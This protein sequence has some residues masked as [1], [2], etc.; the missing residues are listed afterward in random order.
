MESKNYTIKDIGR[1]AGVSAG[2]VDRVLHNRGDVSAEAMEKVQKVLK[3]IDYHPNMFAIGLAAKKRYNIVCMLPYSEVYNNY[4][5]AVMQGINFA[6]TEFKPFNVK[7]DFLHYWHSDRASYEQAC[8]ELQKTSAD[9]VLIAPNFYTET[10]ELTTHLDNKQIPYVFVDYNVANTYPLCYIGQ[11]SRVSGYMA[12]KLLMQGYKKGEELVLFMNNQKENPAE[13]QMQRRM[14][15]FM[16]Y[17][18]EEQDCLIIHDVILDKDDEVNARVLD[19]FFAAHPAAVLGAV[20][21]SRIYRVASHLHENGMKLKRL[22]GYD[23]LQKNI[24]FMKSGEIDCLIGQRPEQQGYCG[25]KALCDCIVFK[26][27]VK[28][29][30]YIPID[31]LMKENIDFYTEFNEQL[32]TYKI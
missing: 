14:D 3:D 30:Q 8:A 29:V 32:T 19:E 27:P 2:T 5:Y 16:Q 11:D 15:G 7:V 9:G 20:F 23:L 18:G 4:W 17:L 25:V 12:A 26:R 1:L 13:I 6:V 28:P 10:I 22:V 24:E 31:I 21:N